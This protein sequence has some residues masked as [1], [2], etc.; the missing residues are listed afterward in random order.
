MMAKE[1]V[2][3]AV[4]DMFGA[5]GNVQLNE[6]ELGD[7]YSIRVE[8]LRDLIEV[9][10]REV[11]MLETNIRERLRGDRGYRAKPSTG[12]VRPWPRSWSPRSVM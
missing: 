7:A 11:T 1:G 6:M 4:S 8:S 5:A 3:P 9:Y 2:L 12:S 10:D